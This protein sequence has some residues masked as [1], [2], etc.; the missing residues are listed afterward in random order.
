MLQGTG[1]QIIYCK[2]N[3]INHHEYKSSIT[4]VILHMFSHRLKQIDNFLIEITKR[5]TV[6][7]TILS[8]VAG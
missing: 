3:Y 2:G 4:A 7:V 5:K 6:D 1:C 8:K